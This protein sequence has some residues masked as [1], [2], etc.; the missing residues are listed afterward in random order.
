MNSDKRII[1]KIIFVVFITAVI[2]T[3]FQNLDTVFKYISVILSIGFPFILGGA[4]AFLVNI[5]MSFIERIFFENK[6]IKNNRTVRSIKRPLS[7]VLALAAI[8]A[9]VIGVFTVVIPQLTVTVK[10]LGT[11]IYRFLPI[12]EKKILAIVNNDW[13]RTQIEDIFAEFNWNSVTDH[14]GAFFKSSSDMITS[15]VGVVSNIFSATVNTVI[16]FIFSVYILLQ[17]EKLGRQSKK[18]ILSIFSEKNSQKIFYL[19]ELVYKTFNKFVTGQCLEAVILGTLFFVVLS[20]ARMPYALLI[21]VLIG[22]TALIPLVGAFIGCAVSAFLILM[23]SPVKAVIFLVI[24]IIIQQLE[25][26][27]IY[28]H[29][30]GN[31][32]GLPSMWVL[33]AVTLGGSLFGVVGMLVFIPMSSVLYTLLREWSQK[34]LKSRGIKV[35]NYI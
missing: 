17:R 33:V 35:D 6:Y 19:G 3:C 10:E 4:I 28:P 9:V 2:F 22:F 30:V 26:N 27:L 12:A 15:T 7:L 8:I 18:L 1:E 32:V 25:G 29:V 20:I 24:F 13:F 14:L 21:G 5:P 34:R 31:S 11:T 16:A 23:V